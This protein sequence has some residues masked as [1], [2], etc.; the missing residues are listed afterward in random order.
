MVCHARQRL[1]EFISESLLVSAVCRHFV[2]FVND[3]QVPTA[4]EK[5]ILG[6]LDSG[7][8]R[9]RRDDLI[10][11]LP[12]IHAVIGT[13]HVAADDLKLLSEFFLHLSL[14]L[15]REAGGCDDERSFDQTTY[16]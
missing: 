11:F 16:L 2:G 14:P 8:P 12:W 6:I 13:K 10:P 7:N 9:D 1:S 4:S 3:D 5:A 15:K